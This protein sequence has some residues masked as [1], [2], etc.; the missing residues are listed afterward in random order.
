MEPGDHDRILLSPPLVTDDDVAEV[1]RGLQSGWAAPAGPI[2]TE[3]E[4]AI[5]SIVGVSHAVALS[6]GS[7][8]LQLGL[9]AL[10]VRPGDRVLVPTLTFA[11][12]AFAAVHVGARP[13]FVDVCS[14]YGL[15]DPELLEIAI[16]EIVAQGERVGA[17]I[18]VD[19]FGN[20]AD[21]SSLLAIADTYGIPV[22]EDA[23]EAL[24]AQHELG[25][26]G[27]IGNAA[28]I[29]FNGNKIITTAGGGMLVSDDSE[30]I[31]KVRYWSQQS[32]SSAP[33][34]EHEE[35]GYNF[36]MSSTLASLGLSQSRR[37][38]AIVRH[39]Q[40]V[41]SWYRHYLNPDQSIRFLEDPTWGVG[42][43]WLTV[44]RFDAETQPHTSRRVREFLDH[45]GIE[46]RPAF[47]PMHLQP[48]F[49]N[50]PAFVNGNAECFFNEALCMPSGEALQESDVERISELVLAC[51]A[52]RV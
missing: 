29:S 15:M 44:V 33:W 14:T 41:R 10:G 21:Y 25:A 48:V 36:R 16:R 7:T 49:L 17:I 24:G 23:A 52:D 9:N 51:L 18:P 40:Q 43:S 47:K 4:S 30:L 22:L 11:A 45:R 2:L 6:S 46:T 39:R 20:P 32:R 31:A 38:Q 3:F 19:T 12:P 1:C 13:V 37:L 8:A 26:A 28:V 50:E 5:A 34:Y 35:I 27:S 42:N